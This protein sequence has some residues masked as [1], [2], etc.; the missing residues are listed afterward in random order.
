MFH[1][2]LYAL[3]KEIVHSGTISPKEGSLRTFYTNQ[4]RDYLSLG[5][6]SHLKSIN[7]CKIKL[8]HLNMCRTEYIEVSTIG[9]LLHICVHCINQCW[10]STLQSLYWKLWK[11]P[12]SF[13]ALLRSDSGLLVTGNIVLLLER[14]VRWV[15]IVQIKQVAILISNLSTTVNIFSI[16]MVCIF[17]IELNS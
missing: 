16:I 4:N 5:L 7:I 10:N 15:N 8:E 11:P 13:V 1:Y 12:C 6:S 3:F 9:T 2:L 14:K 17:I